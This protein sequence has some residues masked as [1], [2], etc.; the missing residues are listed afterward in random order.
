[1]FNKG[2]WVTINLT[3]LESSGVANQRGDSRN[4]RRICD[5]IFVNG[6]KVHKIPIAMDSIRRIDVDKF[7]RKRD[8][9]PKFRKRTQDKE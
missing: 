8:P 9:K 2:E 6:Y 1:M 7:Q 5:D 3:K 4:R